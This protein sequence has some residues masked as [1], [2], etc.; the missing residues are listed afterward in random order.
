MR[1]M[2]IDYGTR[3]IGVAI[4]DELQITSRPLLTLR[5]GKGQWRPLEQIC[6]LVLEHEIGLLLVGLPLRMDGTRG[7][8]AR[9]VE[10]VINSL[11]KRLSLP[12]VAVDERLTSREADAILREHGAGL[13]ERRERS[14]E[15]AAAIILQQYL[16]T[17]S[18]PS[19]H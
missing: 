2:A 11:R 14:D 1:V 3:A 16:D 4:S 10:E 8:A 13:R 7:D 6:R 18:S 12:V 5:R 9:R 19:P 15:L 17:T